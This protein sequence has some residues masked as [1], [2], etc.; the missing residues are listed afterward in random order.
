M[1]ILRLFQKKFFKAIFFFNKINTSVGEKKEVKCLE[2]CLRIQRMLNLNYAT[3]TE[4]LLS[5][6]CK[7]NCSLHSSPCS[8]I[9]HSSE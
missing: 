4:E 1:E 5:S 7:V 9:Y 2:S 6:V 8:K 3:D